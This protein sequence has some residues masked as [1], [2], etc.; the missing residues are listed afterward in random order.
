[1]D[2]ISFCTK[3]FNLYSLDSDQVSRFELDREQQRQEFEAEIKTYRSNALRNQCTIEELHSKHNNLQSSSNSFDCIQCPANFNFA[4][5]ADRYDELI[6]SLQQSDSA[7]QQC[8]QQVAET[9]LS[10]QKQQV[11]DKSLSVMR[12]FID[13]RCGL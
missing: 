10:F 12:R 9:Q 5:H 4:I 8:R 6:L 2:S 3:S 13:F 1:L 7:L 11:F